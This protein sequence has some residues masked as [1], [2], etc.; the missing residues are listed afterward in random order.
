MRHSPF[1]AELASLDDHDP[2]AHAVSAGLVVL[3]LVDAWVEEGG[4]VVAADGWGVRSV[5]AAIQQMPAG[6]P[7]RAILGSVLTTLIESRGGDMH[8]VSPKLMAYARS[9]DL[10]AK[11]DLAADVYRTL[12]A[13]AHPIEE[14]DVVIAAH[15]GLAFCQ[16]TLGALDEAAA[17][18]TMASAVANDVDDMFGIL[19]AQIGIA[20][21]SMHR[22]NLPHAESLLDDVIT[23]ASARGDLVDLHASALQERAGVAFFRGRYDVAVE[24]AYASLELTAD[25]RNRDRLLSDIGLAFSKLGVH[26]AARDAYLIVEATAQEQ[27]QRWAASMNLMELAALEGAM[28]VFERYRR[29]LTQMPFPPQL[30][31]QFHL[32]VAASY[33]ALMEPGSAIRASEQAR[34]VAQQF[35]FHQI[36]FE[37]GALIDRVE[38]GQRTAR[39]APEPE[40]GGPVRTV[41]RSLS[42]MRHR[43]SK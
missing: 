1:F 13:H 41:A 27:Y 25:P 14:S 22:G 16:R 33:E 40:L 2:A 10:D 17:S 31:A 42:T 4:A 6:M 30:Q 19:R 9:L 32:Q 12:I 21:I 34:E 3:R 28:P 43:L 38:H 39:R 36:S 11:W 29:S 15:F 8:A 35:G 23:R 18:Y 26:S 20:G 24:L 37:A 5:E 7:A